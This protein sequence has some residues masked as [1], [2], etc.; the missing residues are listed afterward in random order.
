MDRKGAAEV[1]LFETFT[2]CSWAVAET[3]H[4]RRAAI[5]NRIDLM[6]YSLLI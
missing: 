4:R 1:P 3:V 2:A 6:V 5:R